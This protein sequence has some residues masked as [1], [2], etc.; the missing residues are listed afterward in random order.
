MNNRCLLKYYLAL[1]MVQCYLFFF[2]N[3]LFF[4]NF[5]VFILQSTLKEKRKNKQ[6]N[7]QTNFT[8]Y[9]PPWATPKTSPA[10]WAWGGELFEA[11]LSWG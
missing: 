10:L 4:I 5:E 6:T 1:C 7:K 2:G 3:L 9:H 8:S 11:V